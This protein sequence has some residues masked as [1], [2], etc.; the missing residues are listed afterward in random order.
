MK[1]QSAAV[2]AVLS[3][4]AATPAAAV[5]EGWYVSVDG[6]G[7][8]VDEWEHLRTLQT[9]CGPEFRE[10]IAAFDT[11]YAAFG[12]IGF[13][14]SSWRIEVEGGYRHNGIETSV[15][16]WGRWKPGGDG[17]LTEVTA[18]VNVLYDIPLFD[19]LAL[20]IGLGAGGDYTTLELDTGWG[21]VDESD[22]RFAYQGIAGLSYA[23]TP[24]TAVF[25]NYRYAVVGGNEFQPAANYTI[26]GDEFHKQ[27]ATA[28]VRF[29]LAGPAAPLP[30]PPPATP[31]PVPLERE[32]IVFFGFNR[33]DLTSQARATIRNAVGSV[34]DSGSA[35][36]QVVGHAD[37][38]GSISYNKALSV[39]RAKS[40]KGA[41]IAEGVA[42]DTISVSGRGE[43][44]PSVPTAD[45]VREPQNRRVHIS[46]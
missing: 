28:G 42:A 46:F 25:L 16:R 45:G 40:V 23:I 14:I 38:S 39:R 8:W 10:A 7:S 29:Q 9:W 24:M 5:T 43:S 22:W 27:A 35:A 18:M 32:F 15:W 11:G 30:P 21:P 2:A 37:R 34:R 3:L 20:S 1:L 13:G 26:E 31:Q 44:E 17:D 36:I 4:L 12:A 41:L 19:R 6:G 33:A